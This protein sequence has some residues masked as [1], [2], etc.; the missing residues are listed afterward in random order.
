MMLP[1][2]YLCVCKFMYIFRDTFLAGTC[3][4]S[5]S[6]CLFVLWGHGD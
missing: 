2:F 3:L 4:V 1:F 6:P 5:L